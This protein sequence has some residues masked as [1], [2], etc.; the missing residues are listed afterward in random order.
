MSYFL[1]SMVAWSSL[2]FYRGM[3]DYQHS[4]YK[5]EY[6][7]LYTNHFLHGVAGSICYVNPGLSLFI[8]IPKEI[9]RLEVNIRG[10]HYEKYTDKYN[11]IF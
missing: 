6:P 1:K 11:E 8:F 10:L 3:M 4:V 2:G 7:Y 5:Y 9:Y